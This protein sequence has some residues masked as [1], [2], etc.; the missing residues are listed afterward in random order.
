MPYDP[1]EWVYR[2]I[3]AVREDD[4]Y[5]Y[6][7]RFKKILLILDSDDQE[8]LKSMVAEVKA[9]YKLAAFSIYHI[10]QYLKGKHYLKLR[11][12]Y[13][14]VTVSARKIYSDLQLVDEWVDEK[15]R[16]MGKRIRFSQPLDVARLKEKTG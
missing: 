5:Y 2:E 12:E 9:K 11:T 16:E 3:V 13:D 14:I 7:K 1:R 15:L 10:E 8:K 6:Y 4:D